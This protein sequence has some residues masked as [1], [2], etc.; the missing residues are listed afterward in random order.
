MWF[1]ID[2]MEEMT[3][4]ERLEY[5][6]NNKYPLV[7]RTMNKVNDYIYNGKRSD[8]DTDLSYNAFGGYIIEPMTVES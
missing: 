3:P 1:H 4:E 7:H 5:Y 6:T 2:D 8:C